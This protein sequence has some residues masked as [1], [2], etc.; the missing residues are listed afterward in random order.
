MSESTAGTI[1]YELEYTN[2]EYE[3]LKANKVFVNEHEYEIELTFANVEHKPNPP[4]TGRIVRRIRI[5]D[6]AA[7]ETMQQLMGLFAK[8]QRAVSNG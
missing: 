2:G 7:E 3:L 1:G 5:P 8:K 6:G 4:H